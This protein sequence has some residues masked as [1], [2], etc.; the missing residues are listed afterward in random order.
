M[1]KPITADDLGATMYVPATHE[2]L[3]AV[4]QGEKYPELLSMVICLEDAVLDRDIPAALTNMQ[5]TLETLATTRDKGTSPL[6]F[7]RPRNLE[8]AEALINDP[9]FIM[10]AVDGL[11]LPKFTLASLPEW[12]R[13][14]QNTH[15]L[16]MPTLEDA[17]AY[18]AQRM[19]EL[20]VTL[21]ELAGDRVIAI[22]IGGNDLMSVL[23]LRRDKTHT[24]Y[25]GPLGYVI[26]MLVSIFGSQGF[27]LTS[28]VC[29]LIDDLTVLRRE[30]VQDMLHGLVGKTAIHPCQIPVIHQALKVAHK[31][32]QEAL[33]ILNADSA[34]FKSDGTMCEPATHRNWA[35]R[36]INRGQKFGYVDQPF[37]D[38][39]NDFC[40]HAI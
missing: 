24:L 40:H 18:N 36:I 12:H 5:R 29:E 9:A 17:E 19:H 37:T 4:A 3:L 2:D 32:Y 6:V 13:I 8:M 16:W 25:E 23:G 27:A 7:I 22:R 38:T 26:K 33:K 21:R 1:E 30:L 35:R 39:D 34:V 28:P 20:A 15:L 14:C 31:D 11:V 10:T